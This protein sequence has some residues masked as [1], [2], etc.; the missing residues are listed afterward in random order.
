[1]AIVQITNTTTEALAH[2]KIDA[3][4]PRIS[5][6]M[7]GKATH[8]PA[9]AASKN[10][11][12]QQPRILAV[13]LSNAS[14]ER[15]SDEFAARYGQVYNHMHAAH[16]RRRRVALYVL[17][18]LVLTGAFS[19]LFAGEPVLIAIAAVVGTCGSAYSKIVD[20]KGHEAQCRARS[21]DFGALLARRH[22][23][24]DAAFQRQLSQLQTFD[25]PSERRRLCRLAFNQVCDEAGIPEQKRGPTWWL[26]R[27]AAP[28]SA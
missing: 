2:G 8:A 6:A 17:D 25:E 12:M 24:D 28:A 1:M 18:V 13:R 19:A 21:N 26:R 7:A 9:T 11:R 5:T 20:L 14:T 16:L 15:F 23:L 22:D 3:G 27:H 10:R 4:R